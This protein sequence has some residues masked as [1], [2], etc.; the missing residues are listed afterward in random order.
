MKR[1]H[2]K[3]FILFAIIVGECI[4]YSGAAASK[5]NILW[6]VAN[7]LSTDLGCY[8]NTQV[9]TPHLDQLAKEGVV[10]ENF[11]TVGAVCSTSRS[12]LITGMYSVSI[13]S[14]NQFTKYKKPLPAPVVPF[15]DHLKKAGYFVTNSK[16]V[17]LENTGYYTGYNFAH[18][19]EELFDGTDWRNSAPD[20]PFFAQVHL[21]YAHRPFEADPAHPVDPDKVALPPYY[22]DHPLARKDWA[23]YLET[24]QLLDRQIGEIL[25]RLEEDGLADNTI[26]FFFAD[27]GRPHVRGKQFLYDGG[28]HSPLIVRWPGHL[29]PGNQED[30]L[31]SNVD[32]AATAMHLADIEIPDYMHGQD[33]LGEAA[34]AR[35]YIFAMRDRCDGTVDRIRAVRTKDFKY[36]RNFY[37]EIP[38]T[39]FNAYKK[40]AYPVLTLLQVMYKNDEL[41]PEQ[42][43]FMAPFRP[44]E[45]LYDLSVDPFE[46]RNLAGEQKYQEKMA[47]LRAEL[48]RWLSAVDI[49]EYPEVSVEIQEAKNTMQADFKA[50]MKKKGLDPNISDED[51]LDYWENEFL[52]NP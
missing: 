38:Y 49:A 34:N 2:L 26:V 16:G 52:K 14:H 47:E 6:I 35:R 24:I 43:R 29:I 7:D 32:L 25:K 15:T 9:H 27:H 36:I 5:P 44:A 21:T 19:A 28:I 4:P 3:S 48:D 10:Y 18:D 20:Q 30:R 51:F 33:F 11:F 37:P 50:N 39:Q 1:M 23:L 42:A 12:S 41:S 17:Q 40:W 46:M 22:P 45:E 31:I 13:N 8:G